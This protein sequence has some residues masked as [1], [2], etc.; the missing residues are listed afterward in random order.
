[1]GGCLGRNKRLIEFMNK[2]FNN[3]AEGDHGKFIGRIRKTQGESAVVPYIK[4]NMEQILIHYIGCTWGA[5]YNTKFKELI[6]PYFDDVKLLDKILRSDI[7][8]ERSN[9][10]KGKT[11]ARIFISLLFELRKCNSIEIKEYLLREFPIS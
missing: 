3:I 1:M 8:K 2:E 11:G 4:A 7:I 9:V 10:V 6:Q 5:C